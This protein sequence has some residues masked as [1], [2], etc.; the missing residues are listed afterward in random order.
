MHHDVKRPCAN[1]GTGQD[2]ERRDEDAHL[3]HADRPRGQELRL[4]AE[5]N[6]DVEHHAI[7]MD[8]SAEEAKKSLSEIMLFFDRALSA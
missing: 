3:V 2:A 8:W 1:H 5:N 7:A 4:D 6:S